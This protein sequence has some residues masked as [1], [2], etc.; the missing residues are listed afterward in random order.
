MDA[1]PRCPGWHVA[2]EVSHGISEMRTDLFS[3][4]IREASEARLSGLS[5]VFALSKLATLLGWTR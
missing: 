5:D 1:F 3:R 2:K 4:M